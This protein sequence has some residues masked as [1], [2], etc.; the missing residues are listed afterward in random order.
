MKNSIK[1]I[2]TVIT[3]LFCTEIFAQPKIKQHQK[4]QHQ[5]IHQ[6]VNSGEITPAEKQRLANEQKRIRMEK[7]IAKA[8][9]RFSKKEKAI[10]HREQQHASKDIYEAKHNEIKK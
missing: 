10:I 8:D 5:R 3:L 1:I 6:G 4:N 7:R 9:G 2:A